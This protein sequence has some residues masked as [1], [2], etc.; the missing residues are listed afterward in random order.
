M[1]RAALCV[2][3]ALAAAAPCPSV[4]CKVFANSTWCR[5]ANVTVSG[6]CVPP[7][8]FRCVAVVNASSVSQVA[9]CGAACDVAGVS[10]SVFQASTCGFG[11]GLTSSVQCAA[12]T[13]GGNSTAPLP[14]LGDGAIAGIMVGFAVAIGVVVFSYC[15]HVVKHD[16]RR[17]NV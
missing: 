12:T 10:W 7:F 14:A 5:G 3:A 1:S 9:V 17:Q 11:V 6:D 13:G 2:L 8:C 15:W 4:S 16:P